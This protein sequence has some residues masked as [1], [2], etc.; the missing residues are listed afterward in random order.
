MFPKEIVNTI[1]L[2]GP[3]GKTRVNL[4]DRPGWRQNALTILENNS[5][6]GTVFVPE[7]DFNDP[8]FVHHENLDDKLYSEQVEWENHCMNISD[9]IIFNFCRTKTNLGLT[10][11]IEFGKYLKSRRLFVCVPPESINNEYIIEMCKREKIT[12]YNTLEECIKA[13]LDY[14]N[15]NY[16][17]NGDIEV[18]QIIWE[19]KE[20]KEWH[21][22]QK[23]HGNDIV[24]F[25]I[26]TI[27]NNDKSSR[28]APL[29]VAKPWM[30]VG[31]HSI[32][33]IDED[34]HSRPSVCSILLYSIDTEDIYNSRFF[35]VSEFRCNMNN[36]SGYICEIPGGSIEEEGNNVENAIRELKEE[37][38]ID[39]LTLLK[40]DNKECK[41]I[42]L[43][44]KQM[45]GTYT[46]YKHIAY[47]ILIPNDIMDKIKEITNHKVFGLKNE[48]TWPKIFTLNDILEKDYVDWSN[49]GVILTTLLKKVNNE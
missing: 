14:L 25:E 21:K 6:S 23:I 38:G 46:I 47:S 18:P 29:W 40:E 26:D 9:A 20:F 10:T 22:N 19:N 31:S 43:G 8:N 33:K 12:I 13:C 35:L 2:A 15:P 37:T 7:D 44:N 11:N 17:N 30:N 16:R 34:L 41:I 39:I 28:Y 45:S 4:L 48:Y 32:K 36:S 5:Y 27:I 1:F 24:K 3:T 42:S 49:T